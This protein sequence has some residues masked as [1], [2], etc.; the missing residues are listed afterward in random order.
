MTQ[1]VC[2]VKRFHPQLPLLPMWIV[3][4]LYGRLSL[5]V[6]WRFGPNCLNVL[7]ISLKFC[8]VMHSNINEITRPMPCV[9]WKYAICHDSPWSAMSDNAVAPTLSGFLNSVWNVVEWWL[10]KWQGT[11][12]LCYPSNTR[13]PHGML[14]HIWEEHPQ[15]SHETKVV[16]RRISLCDKKG[17]KAYATLKFPVTFAEILQIILIAS[18]YVYDYTVKPVCNDHLSNK[19]YYLWFF[20]VMCFNKNWWYQFTRAN[21]FC[22]WSSSRWPV[23]T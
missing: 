1:K 3:V 7:N 15:D 19:I 12:I 9:L 14:D 16:L 17:L 20:S 23:A 2:D 18:M 8:R 22:L 10:L 5:L 21:N 11:T 6:E 13:T 4:M